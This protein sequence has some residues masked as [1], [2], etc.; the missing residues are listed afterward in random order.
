MNIQK[1]TIRR[2]APPSFKLYTVEIQRGLALGYRKNSESSASWTA[3]RYAGGKY[4]YRVWAWLMT[5]R[6]QTALPFSAS[7]RLL[8]LP[9]PLQPISA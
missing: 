4:E 8:K 2:Y 1:K 9:E 7:I 6:Q 3:R 5:S